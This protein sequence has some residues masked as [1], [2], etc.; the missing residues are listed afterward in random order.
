MLDR[1]QILE[2]KHLVWLG[3]LNTL[4]PACTSS[5]SSTWHKLQST[6]EEIF[7]LRDRLPQTGLWAC[8]SGIFLI[9]TC[10]RV[11]QPIVDSAIPG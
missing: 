9:T 6:R 10:C 7:Q 11:A 5:F 8:L 1:K 3:D 4:I 2:V